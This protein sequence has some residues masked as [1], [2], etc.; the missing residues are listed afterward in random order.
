MWKDDKCLSWAETSEWFGLIGITPVPVLYEGPFSAER[1]MEVT[2]SLSADKQ[3]GVVV[4]SAGEFL[5]QDFQKNV[6]KYVRAGHVQTDEHWMSGPVIPNIL[7]A[8][9]RVR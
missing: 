1:I 5:M 2:N 3:E 4:R 6:L 8:A 7:R 9:D